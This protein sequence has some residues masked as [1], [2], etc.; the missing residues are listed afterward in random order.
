MFDRRKLYSNFS[1]N[2][3][4][5]LD[6][7]TKWKYLQELENYFAAEQGRPAVKVLMVPSKDIDGYYGE[8]SSDENAIYIN[9]DLVEYGTLLG[10]VDKNHPTMLDAN[11]Q[12][13]DT[14]AHEGYHAY[15]NYAIEH[16]GFHKD[17]KQVKEWAI[18]DENVKIFDEGDEYLVQ[19]QERDAWKY[20]SEKTREAFDEIEKYYGAEPGRA[21]YEKSVEDNSY[22]NALERLWNNNPDG[23]NQMYKEMMDAYEERY[24]ENNSTVNL[25]SITVDEYDAISREA[26]NRYYEH[27]KNNPSLSN[28]DVM[29]MT[30]EMSEKYFSAVEEY[31]NAVQ[32][33]EKSEDRVEKENRTEKYEAQ[34]QENR[35]IFNSDRV[36]VEEYDKTLRDQVNKY[37]EH[38]KNDPSLSNEDVMRMTEEMSEKY[39]TAVE[40]YR[41]AQKQEDEGFQEKSGDKE[42]TENRYKRYKKE[43][44]EKENPEHKRDVENQR[45][46]EAE[47]ENKS[48]KTDKLEN[49][50][51]GKDC[52]EGGENKDKTETLSE[53]ELEEERWN[54]SESEDEAELL[55]DKAEAEEEQN[56]EDKAVTENESELQDNAA[57]LSSEESSGETEDNSET[58]NNVEDLSSEESSEE[59]EE[60]SEEEDKA[61]D[62][63]SEESTEE[64]EEE[65]E[66]EDKA[67]D[68]SSEENSGKIEEESEEEDEAKDLSSEENSEET[69]EESEEEDKAEDLSSG[70]DDSTS[71]ESGGSEET[72]NYSY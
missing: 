31:K 19:P 49:R 18:N 15:Q 8:Y 4:N 13:F 23:L 24:R 39:L 12:L 26:V 61:E 38:L 22:E 62:L 43:E 32:Q 17:V 55:S 70:E 2:K 56:T 9:R 46:E 41:N 25:D 16:P 58:E 36:S 21:M 40:E 51:D 60:E 33:K 67:E 34:N 5:Q 37:Y 29:R 45:K 54:E 27:L 30:G 42:S 64:T 71:Y 63:S 65:S 57:D 72:E 44:I 7:D 52:E 50:E 66:E 53:D 6:I 14:I 47:E 48:E 59:T 11:M 68:L 69:E 28:E 10:P 1:Y 20:G 35:S 3:W